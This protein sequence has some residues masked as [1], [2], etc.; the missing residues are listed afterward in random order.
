MQLD[1]QEQWQLLALLKRFED[2]FQGKLGTWNCPPVD[3][4]LKPGSK[5][6]HRRPYTSPRVYVDQVKK[7]CK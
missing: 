5:S 4:E 1:N 7:E 2:L 3:L 6:Y